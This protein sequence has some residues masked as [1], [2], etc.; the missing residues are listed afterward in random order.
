MQLLVTSLEKVFLYGQLTSSDRPNMVS[1][2]LVVQSAGRGEACW[3]WTDGE[4]KS[5]LHFV[6]CMRNIQC[7]ICILKL[8]AIHSSMTCLSFISPVFISLWM[9]SNIYELCFSK[10]LCLVL[11]QK[12][13]TYLA[14]DISEF[15]SFLC[16]GKSGLSWILIQNWNMQAAVRKLI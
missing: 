7:T 12:L 4:P 1:C 14:W 9:V 11:A 15:D 6:Y 2:G 13:P 8:S 16:R 3:C 5:H 10:A